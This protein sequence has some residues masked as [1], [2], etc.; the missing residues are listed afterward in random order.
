MSL[1]TGWLE[2]IL[3]VLDLGI[4]DKILAGN[5]PHGLDGRFD[6]GINEIQRDKFIGL[7]QQRTQRE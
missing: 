5:H 1:A 6:V 7:C 4:K 3:I 2:T